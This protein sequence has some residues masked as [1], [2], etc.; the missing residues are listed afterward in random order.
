MQSLPLESVS[1]DHIGNSLASN[2]LTPYLLRQFPRSLVE[3]LPN[4]LTNHSIYRRCDCVL[5]CLRSVH[6]QWNGLRQVSRPRR[7]PSPSNSNRS[8]SATVPPPSLTRCY[9]TQLGAITGIG[10]LVSYLFLF[11]R[12][13]F[14]TY[15]VSRK[16][17]SKT[18]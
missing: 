2:L 1:K 18:H 10:I 6:C 9:G 16:P 7:L 15:T 5:L 3:A 14:Q 11:V 4:N 12:F 17:R 13:Y 8:N